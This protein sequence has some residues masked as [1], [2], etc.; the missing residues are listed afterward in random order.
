MGLLNTGKKE[1]CA[2]SILVWFWIFGFGNAGKIAMWA[3]TGEVV[4]RSVLEG[5]QVHIENVR[6]CGLKNSI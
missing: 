2:Q 5:M 1:S 3:F 4:K 6:K